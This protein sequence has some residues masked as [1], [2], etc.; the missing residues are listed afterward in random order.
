MQTHKYDRGGPFRFQTKSLGGNS[1]FDWINAGGQ[2][3]KY[4]IPA[5]RMLGNERALR[6]LRKDSKLTFDPVSLQHGVVRDIPRPNITSRYRPTAG[7]SLAEFIYGQ[8]YADASQRAMGADFE[9]QNASSRIQQERDIRNS[10]NQEILLN[11]NLQAGA[12]QFNA[13]NA[14]NEKLIRMANQEELELGLT[15]TALNDLSQKNYLDAAKKAS[16][17]GNVLRY[18][19]PGSPEYQRALKYYMDTIG[20]MNM[21]GK[22]KKKTKFSHGR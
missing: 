22:L 7:S 16:A 2:A 18:G 11:A 9:V 1:G 19:D 3:L 4:I 5:A 15:E 8:K 21:G 14:Q 13:Q 10:R 12:R 17:A 6:S 20:E